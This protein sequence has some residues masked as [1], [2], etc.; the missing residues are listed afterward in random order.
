MTFCIGVLQESLSGEF[1]FGPHR[2]HVTLTSHE[3]QIEVKLTKHH[4]IK[5]YPMLHWAPRHGNVR[6]SGVIASHIL[7]SAALTPGKEPPVITSRWLR[8]LQNCPV[9]ILNYPNI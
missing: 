3:A 7:T 1:N 4:V 9:E 6:G 5:T 8:G 2:P